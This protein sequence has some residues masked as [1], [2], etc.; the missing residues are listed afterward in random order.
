M[1]FPLLQ[2]QSSGVACP[3]A[4]GVV[5]HLLQVGEGLM[6][7]EVQVYEQ[8]VCVCVGGGGGGV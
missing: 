2:A 1:L 7:N 6:M 5:D 3:V 4:A 8:G